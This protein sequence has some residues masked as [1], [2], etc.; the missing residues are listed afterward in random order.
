M[1]LAM[2]DGEAPGEQQVLVQA[3]FI[4]GDSQADSRPG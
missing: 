1:L 4:T 2:V 3:E